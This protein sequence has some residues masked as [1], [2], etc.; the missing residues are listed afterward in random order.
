MKKRKVKV[1]VSGV[2]GDVAQGVIKAL[3][4]SLLDLEI[5]KICAYHNSSWLHVDDFSF[6]TPLSVSDEYIPFL[7]KFLNK[8]KVDVFFPCIDSEINKVSKNK[9]IIEDSTQTIVFVDEFDKIKR[10]EDKYMTYEFL[11]MNNF[12]CPA[13]I[14]PLSVKDIKGLIKHVGFPLVAKRRIG[15]GA[16]SVKFVNTYAEARNYLGLADYVLQEFLQSEEDEFTSGIYLGD[17]GEV[18]G[19]CI[20]KRE[21][22]G[23]STY[24]AVRIID[25]RHEISLC[26]MAKKLGM[27]YLNIQSRLRKGHLCPFEFNPRF[28]G[29]TGIISRVFNAPEFFIRERILK[30]KCDKAQ[31]NDR[32]Y[33]MRYYEEIY[34]SIEDMK[35]LKRRSNKI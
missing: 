31:N 22:K 27:K 1:L 19:I 13:T 15:H 4:K 24:R 2:G 17:D 6:I 8:F 12:K 3:Q 33:V 5:Y 35:E 9:K 16:E 23:G 28:S 30:E 32:F 20:L 29:T 34:A 14:L 10:C 11:K 7:I 18:K 25:K 26:K 21:L